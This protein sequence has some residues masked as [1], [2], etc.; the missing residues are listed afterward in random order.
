MKSRSR[1]YR[2]PLGIDT[3]QNT[4]NAT[5]IYITSDGK[6]KFDTN[7]IKDRRCATVGIFRISCRKVDVTQAIGGCD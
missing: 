4:A 2:L 1:V 6:V 5:S 7:I 3:S